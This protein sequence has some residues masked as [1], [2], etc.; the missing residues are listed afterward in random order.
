[1]TR[2]RVSAIIVSFPFFAR[3][4]NLSRG[5]L[6]ADHFYEM[7]PR[8]LAAIPAEVPN[9]LSHFLSEYHVVVPGDVSPILA[10]PA[11]VLWGVF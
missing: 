11:A 8:P 10:S 5:R 3:M 1:M 2:S 6:V 9:F 4:T 7:L